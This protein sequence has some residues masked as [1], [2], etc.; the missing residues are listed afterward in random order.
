MG[1]EVDRGLV[2]RVL[3][4]RVF[5]PVT[6]EEMLAYAAAS[7][8]TAP[9]FVD[10]AAARRGPFGTLVAP[11]TFPLSLHAFAVRPENLPSLGATSFDA[12]KDIEFGEPVRAGDVL[13]MAT[14]IHDVYEKTGRSG[15]MRFMV[16]RT[17]IT[18][19]GGPMVAI[20]DQ[21]M[22]FR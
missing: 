22:M 17:T 15:S 11:P 19:R 6:R 14:V 18:K 10:E 9:L 3:G 21:Q 5:P 16:L 13:T 20:I 7:G 12:G 2:G 4:E 8:E 1:G